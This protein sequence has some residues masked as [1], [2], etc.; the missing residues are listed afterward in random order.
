VLHID[1]ARQTPDRNNVRVEGWTFDSNAPTTALTVL[2]SV[3]GAAPVGQTANV[4]RPDVAAQHPKDGPY[5]GYDVTIPA[6]RSPQQVCVTAIHVGSGNDSRACVSTD[7]VVGFNA[8]SINYDVAHA[9][10]VA[11][12]LDQLD[13]VTNINSTTVQQSTTI[14]GQ[15]S[16]QDTQGWSDTYGVQVTVKA[17]IGIPL[18]GDTDISV[19]GSAQFVQNGQTQSTVMFSWQQPVLVPAKSEVVAT[20]AATRSTLQVPYTMSGNAVYNSGATASYSIGG[21]YS[22]I[23]SHDFQVTLTQYNLNGT[24][25]ASPRSQPAGKFLMTR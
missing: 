1:L 4:Y 8:S 19:Q 20:V 22:G 6:S 9:Q 11:T 12:N 23:N 16:V 7:D 21:T 2:I 25:A 3:D 24:P 17:T 5:H 10:I 18:V 14:S 13:K 15:T